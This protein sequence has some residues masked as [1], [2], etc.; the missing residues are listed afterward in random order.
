MEKKV[1]NEKLS[2]HHSFLQLPEDDC[3][4]KILLKSHVPRQINHSLIIL[5]VDPT[6]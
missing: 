5:R 4:K 3:E 1:N 2:V 6:L